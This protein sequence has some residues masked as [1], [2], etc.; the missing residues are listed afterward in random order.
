[1][2]EGLGLW[3]GD[4]EEEDRRLM[5]RLREEGQC[6]GLKGPA[7]CT[8]LGELGSLGAIFMGSQGHLVPSL[9]PFAFK[10]VLFFTSGSHASS[11]SGP[12][13]GLSLGQLQ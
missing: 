6:G 9:Q 13:L 7:K 8:K 3:L 12:Q 1:M 4:L 2:G 10:R 11:P 5:V